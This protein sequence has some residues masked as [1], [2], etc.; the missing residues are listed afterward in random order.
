[1]MEY[2]QDVGWYIVQFLGDFA[3]FLIRNP[4]SLIIITL[5]ILFLGFI[6]VRRLMQ[7]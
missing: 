3:M 4:A 5:F 2:T 1:M 7:W 6:A